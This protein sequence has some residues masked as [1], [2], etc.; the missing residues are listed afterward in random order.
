[1]GFMPKRDF[2]ISEKSGLNHINHQKQSY[3]VLTHKNSTNTCTIFCIHPPL[4]VTSYVLWLNQ[5]IPHFFPSEENGDND[6]NRQHLWKSCSIHTQSEWAVIKGRYFNLQPVWCLHPSSCSQYGKRNCT[7]NRFLGLVFIVWGCETFKLFQRWCNMFTHQTMMHGSNS[8]QCKLSLTDNINLHKSPLNV[9]WPEWENQA[10]SWANDVV[11]VF[12]VDR[13]Q[14]CGHCKTKEVFSILWFFHLFF[15]F[16]Q[17]K[18][19]ILYHKW[20]NNHCKTLFGRFNMYSNCTGKY[21]GY[22]IRYPTCGKF[23]H[24]SSEDKNKSDE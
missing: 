13:C 8:N 4:A 2:S 5:Q 20:L 9:K 21:T 19:I 15:F 6:N 14:M 10:S 17:T 18:C 23:P 12:H 1:M 24:Y 11:S 7:S 22:K 16:N 3:E